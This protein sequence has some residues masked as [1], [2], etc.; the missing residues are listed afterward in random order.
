MSI[1][2][3]VGAIPLCDLNQQHESIAGELRDAIDAVIAS[4]EFILGPQVREFERLAAEYCGTR[5]AVG[6]SSGTDALLMALMA[7]EVGPGD[8]AITTP[9]TFFA[10]AGAIWRLGARPVFVDIEHAS[11]NIDPSQIEDAITPQTKAIVPVHLFGQTADMEPI[12]ETARRHGLAVVEDAAQAI[13]AD[14]RGQ[15]AGSIGELGCF[16]F[17]PSKNLG[18]LGDGGMVTTNDD[19]LAERLRT[20]RKHGASQKYFHDRVGGNFR[21][22]TIQAAVLAVKLRYLDSWNEARRRCAESYRDLVQQ[23]SLGDCCVCLDELDGNKHVYQQF[24][25]RVPDRNRLAEALKLAGVATA[26]YYPRPLHLQECFR[27]LGYREGDFPNS[28][29]AS[30]ETLALPMFPGLGLQQQ[31]AVVQIIAQNTQV[32]GHAA[33]S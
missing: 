2:E 10:T 14:Y 9:Y 20:L 29:R 28:E 7:L 27:S 22:D 21:L 31:A 33:A 13:G 15:R 5:H 4:G 18:C 11:F 32:N 3:S 8:E 17:F 26:V 25:V 6:C 24:V 16:S 30:R 23:Y 12:I 19:Q 1:V